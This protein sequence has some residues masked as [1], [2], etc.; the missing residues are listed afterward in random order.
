MR[1][2]DGQILLYDSLAWQYNESEWIKVRVDYLRPTDSTIHIAYWINDELLYEV[3]DSAKDYEVDLDYIDLVA[4]EGTVWFDDICISALPL[5]SL[6]IPSVSVKPCDECEIGYG[7]QPV[8][9]MLTQPIK[10]AS[11]PIEVSDSVEICS[12]STEGC[13]T[14]AWDWNIIDDK[15][16]DSGFVMVA[17]MNSLG[18]TI[19]AG[20]TTVFNVFFTAPRECTASYYIHWDTALSW[21]PM[22]SLL[23]SDTNNQAL[24][25]YFDPNRDSTEILGYLPGNVDDDGGVNVADLT[26]LVDYMFFGGSAPCVL[27]SAD[28]NGDCAVNIADLTY[29]VDYLF[30]SG[31]APVC[32]CLGGGAAA[33]ISTDISVS[34]EYEDGITTI[35][36]NS[37]VALR[38][39]QLELRGTGSTTPMSLLDEQIDLLYGERDDGMRVGL[40][41]LQGEA[42]IESGTQRVIELSGEFEVTEAIVSDMNH[43]GLAVSIGAAKEASLPTVFALHQNFPNPF[44]PTTEISFSLS[45]A[46]YV[47]LKVYNIMGQQV[48]TIVDR[49]ME[50]G[51]HSVTFDSRDGSG[52]PVASGIYFYRLEAGEFVETKKMVLLK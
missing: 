23:F 52:R 11:I 3:D 17:L 36:L 5:D 24:T 2:E 51:T 32:G 7:V 22:R 13:I 26:Y 10:G 43:R 1:F 33:K 37:P 45:Q 38:G 47:R 30:L 16:E 50:A 31:S 12:V 19:P 35:T 14:D 25:A 8:M 48:A 29:L 28:V 34:A 46:T 20:T 27:N 41:D 6:L 49:F 18:Y 40:L 44:N 39:M 15:S 21:D 9:T 42:I 4:E